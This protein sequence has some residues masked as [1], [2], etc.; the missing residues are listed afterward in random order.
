MKLD[1]TKQ[2]QKIAEAKVEEVAQKWLKKL[3][4]LTPEDTFKLQNSNKKSEVATVGTTT[5]VRIYND[6]PKAIY[7]E[8]S[9][10]NKNYYKNWWRKKGWNPF[11]SWKGAWM[12]RKTKFFLE[13]N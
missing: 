8:Y 10:K 3:K 7:V 4:E 5:A 1:F 13:N 6:D 12:F 2:I 9:S 11:Y